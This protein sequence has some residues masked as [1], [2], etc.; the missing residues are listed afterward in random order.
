MAKSTNLYL[1][2]NINNQSIKLTDA[3]TTVTKLAF[4]AE[5]TN[6][7]HI[8]AG[9]AT[10]DDTATVNLKIY[11]VRSAVE[12]LLGVV[13]VLPGAGIDGSTT[14]C[15]LFQVGGTPIILGLPLS[16]VGLFY[17]PLKAGDTIKI[18]C[19]ATMTAAKTC[20]V[21]LFGEDL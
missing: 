21:N 17:L 9:I 1:S 8:I 14:T 15:D 6:G 13:P 2:Q 16:N 20:T 7:S 5:A 3:D 18:G 11:I 4:T 19:L 10:S 12:Y